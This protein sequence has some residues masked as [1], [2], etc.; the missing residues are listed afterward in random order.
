VEGSPGRSAALE[1]AETPFD[2]ATL[3]DEVAA[4][5]APQ[6]EVLKPLGTGGMGA[7]FLAR[8]PALRRLVAIK[9]LAPHLARDPRARVRFEREAQAAAALSHPNVVRVYALGETRTQHL[10]YIVMQY[11]EGTTLGRWAASRQRVAERDARRIIG[12]AAAALAAAHAHGLVHRDV[13]PGNVL[14]EADSGRTFV[15]DFGVSAALARAADDDQ[16]T[17]TGTVVGTPAYMSPEQAAGE[18]VTPKSDVYSLGLVAYELLAGA[19]PYSARTALGWA[20]AHLRD[21]AAPLATRRPDLSPEFSTLVDRCLAKDPAQRPEARDIARALLPAPEHEIPWPPPGLTWLLG[22]SQVLARIATLLFGGFAIATFALAFPPGIL[23]VRENWLGRFATQSAS[24]TAIRL[25]AQDPGTST[26]LLWQAAVIIS[27]TIC[28]ASILA[29]AV[30]GGRLVRFLWQRRARGWHWRTLLDVAADYDGRSGLLLAG[31]R[32]FAAMPQTQRVRLLAARRWRAVAQIIPG[33]WATLVLAAWATALVAG[34]LSNAAQAPTLGAGIFWTT[35]VPALVALVLAAVLERWERRHSAQSV[36]PSDVLETPA[37]VAAWYQELPDAAQPATPLPDPLV[38]GARFLGPAA[39][40][41]AAILVLVGLAAGVTAS[42]IAAIATSRVGPQAALLT[43][44][45]ARIK[46]EDPIGAARRILGP[47]LPTPLPDTDTTVSQRLRQLMQSR[48][49]AASLPDYEPEPSALFLALRRAPPGIAPLPQPPARPARQPGRTGSIA[50]TFV[51]PA[52]IVRRAFEHRLPPDTLRLLETLGHH[53]RTAWFED[54]ARAP[55]WDILG[56]FLDHPLTAYPHLAA[57][58][59]FSTSRLAEA[60]LANFLA[61][62]A[63]LATGR[64]GDARRRLGENA[65]AGLLL[66]RVP[67]LGANQLGRSVLEAFAL[68][69]LAELEQHEG[70]SRQAAELR[71]AARRLVLFEFL[72]YRG[73]SGLAADPQHLD[74]VSAALSEAAYPAGWRLALMSEVMR[75]AC[76]NPREVL[77]GPNARRRTFLLTSAS[78]VSDFPQ[79]D[80]LADLAARSGSLELGSDRGTSLRGFVWRATTCLL[81]SD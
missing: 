75:G 29:L 68:N 6:Y 5:V 32:G 26:Q 54:L 63:D 14:I 56:A 57:V 67:D 81:S 62:A 55:Q 13:K 15:A 58:P 28:A 69:P 16:L 49:Q 19:P 53:P 40:L 3:R 59:V 43:T 31:A 20:A 10:P 77:L 44:V 48:P 51:V 76:T 64:L 2:A 4:S 7:V 71:A 45:M 50:A 1:N 39:L 25:V 23:R 42:V 8:E 74:A 33:C 12:E 11:V 80:A 78:T 46:T 47:Y 38:V 36:G 9:V 73:L 30:T 37:D 72:P 60:A 70:N 24:P 18:P 27:F 34:R 61:A 79:A 66:L 65:A 41:G 52:E 17:L 22:R 35:T 21:R